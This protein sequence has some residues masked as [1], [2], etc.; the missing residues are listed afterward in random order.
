[1]PFLAG[2]LPAVIGAGATVAGDVLGKSGSQTTTNQQ[3]FD[4]QTQAMRDKLFKLLSERL[5]QPEAIDPAL[6]AQGVA[7]INQSA[8]AAV[9]A[10]QSAFSSR[11]LGQSGI[12]G[13][14]LNNLT[15]QRLGG[16]SSLLTQLQG[17]A[18]ERRSRMIDQAL[19]LVSPTG[20][21]ST[22]G[23]NPISGLGAGLS[24]IGTLLGI[25]YG[26]GGNTNATNGV[27]LPIPT[28]GWNPG[29]GW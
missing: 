2:V 20:A 16:I 23:G 19:G 29:G 4:P 12:F 9:P 14:T 25:K 18:E 3:I 11:G 27:P 7:G 22:A 21:S 24:D 1:M 8:N 5:A 28:G 6:M 15:M 26:L 17:T 10:L 13:G